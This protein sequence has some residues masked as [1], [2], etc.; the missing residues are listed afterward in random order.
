MRTGSLTTP[1]CSRVV[2]HVVIMDKSLSACSGDID[3]F[4]GSQ[5]GANARPVQPAGNRVPVYGSFT[6]GAVNPT[7]TGGVPSTPSIPTPP[8][9]TSAPA[10][11]PVANQKATSPK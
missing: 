7:G 8:A 1:P 3:F 2:T 5:V 6:A 10:A 9:A 4:L 11:S